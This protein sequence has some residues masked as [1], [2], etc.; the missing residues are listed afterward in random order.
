MTF[1]DYTEALKALSLGKKLPDAVYLHREA[2]PHA[3]ELLQRLIEKLVAKLD[4]A[5]DYNIYKF[6]KAQFRVSLLSYPEFLNDPHPA[7]EKSILAD[8]GAGKAKASSFDQRVNPPILHRKE[9]FLP[10]DHSQRE[11]FA[12]LTKAEE[13]AG[14]FENPAGI[15]FRENWERL[16]ELKGVKLDGHNLVQSDTQTEDS[17]DGP[18]ISLHRTAMVRYDLSKPVKTLMEKGLLGEKK[19]FFD[20]GC[21]H[22]SDVQGLGALGYQASGWDPVHQPDAEKRKAQI[23]NLG[24]VINVIEDPVERVE[25]LVEAWEHAEELLVVSALIHGRNNYADAKPYKDGVI[26]KSNTFQKYFMQTEL[27][28]YIENALHRDAIPAELGIFYVFRDEA[29]QQDFLSNS[30]RRAINWSE[31]TAKLG[32][33][34]PTPG[35]RKPRLSLYERHQELLDSYWHRLLE[36]GRIPHADEYDRLDE[37]RKACKSPNQAARLFVEKYGQEQFDAAR[38]RR[39]EDLLVYL[40]R[41]EFK[42]R[43]TPFAHL[44]P[45]LR[46]DLKEFFGA[47]H[48]ACDEAREILFASGDPGELELAAEVLPWGHYDE[49][50]GHYAFHA[51]LLGS[52]PPILRVFVG[53]GAM[54]YGDPEECDLIKI[55]LRT[56]KLTLH[57]YN[58]FD[59]EPLPELTLR[60]KI[61][62]K[63]LGVSVFNY[64]EQEE[65][66]LLYFKERY[67]DE[68][69]PER[70]KMDAYSSKLRKLGLDEANMGRFGPTKGQLVQALNQLG[71]TL[72]LNKKRKISS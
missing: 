36:L 15:G 13:E 14:L 2:I 3:P 27:Q 56:S 37:V 70:E 43:R 34:R 20:Y 38:Q 22:G 17:D 9:E 63:H 58:D 28:G 11:V 18:T 48:S 61:D 10:A 19:T 64:S 23:V 44:S 31:I 6:H 4:P 57:F 47:Y 52:L 67:V 16:L 21:G 1:N 39:R 35:E 42:K 50:E 51:S 46:R 26:T 29:A 60:V 45:G 41:E 5:G 54:L 65:T 25:V 53:C 33:E 69:H 55:H 59:Q 62:L 68:S 71:Y 8:V 49:E 66:Q 24:Y 12:K 72:N 40:A 32:F 30:S 7:L